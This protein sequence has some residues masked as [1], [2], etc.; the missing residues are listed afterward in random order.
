MSRFLALLIIFIIAA[1]SVP[2]GDR[3][4]RTYTEYVPLPATVADAI[5]AGWNTT[6][7]CDPVLGIKFNYHGFVP[8]MDSPMTLYFTQ[9]GQAAGVGIEVYGDLPMN[10]INLGFWIQLDPNDSQ[11]HMTVSF[12]SSTEMC[13]STP[14]PNRLGDRLIINADGLAFQIPTTESGA[15]ANNWHKGSCFSG[16]GYHWFFDLSTA[17]VMSWMAENLLP[18]VAMYNN[19]SINAIF[20]ASTSVQQGIFDAHWWEPIPLINALMCKNTCDSDCTFSGTSLWSTFH[21]YLRDYTQVTCDGG[22]TIS[23]CP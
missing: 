11:Y 8:T 10:L 6:G 4:I 22:C 3:L 18:V 14:S 9:A 21:V 17:P 19:N 12:R 1:S 2:I 16:M 23:C 15:L 5:A 13:S 7:L 20:F